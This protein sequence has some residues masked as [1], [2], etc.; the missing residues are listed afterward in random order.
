MRHLLLATSAIAVTSSVAFAEGGISPDPLPPVL[1]QPQTYD[2][3]GGYGGLSLGLTSG[4][5]EPTIP[6]ATFDW[7]TGTALGAFAGYNWQSGQLVYG[8]ELSYFAVYDMVLQGAGANDFVDAILDV[9]GRVGYAFGDVLVYGA[10]GYSIVDTT[11]NTASGQRLDGY[12][13]G[14]GV[15]YHVAE[16]FI[17]GLDF[18][19]RRVDAYIPVTVPA[20]GF[21]L[22]TTVNTLSLRVAYHF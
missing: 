6:L 18:T 3:S 9:R 16:D 21:D 1:V 7:E 22:E 20:G 12:N 10:A 17:V 14:A 5:A 15:E 11:I 2:W 19:S 13:L 4:V 8:A